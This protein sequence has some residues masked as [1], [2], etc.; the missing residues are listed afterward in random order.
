MRRV[1]IVLAVALSAC[2]AEKAPHVV[3]AGYTAACKADTVTL[4]TQ[5]E[6]SFAATNAYTD[7]TTPLHKV[8]VAN[9]TYT[10]AVADARCGTIG[11]TVGQTP[12]DN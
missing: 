8:T 7:Q 1:A 3:H 10:I 4:R 9:G 6:T 12:A 5:E 2:G 11:H